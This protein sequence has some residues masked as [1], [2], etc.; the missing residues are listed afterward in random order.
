GFAR[1]RPPVRRA[2][3]GRPLPPLGHREAVSTP[4]GDFGPPPDA[5]AWSALAL[6]VVLAVLA[7]RRGG[8][9]RLER[10]ALRA[11]WRAVA[12]LA[13]VAAAL[14]AG[15]VAVYLRGGPRII[16]A[17]SYYLQAR[18]LSEGLLSFPLPTPEPSV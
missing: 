17:T 4:L 8:F 1:L 12:A 11:P 15:Y 3:R 7:L 9:V 10:A 5:V 18:A 14:S 16:D 13:L 2:E 6:A